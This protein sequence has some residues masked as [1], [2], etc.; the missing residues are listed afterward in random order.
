MNFIF[1][2][3]SV[4]IKQVCRKFDFQLK[5]EILMFVHGTVKMMGIYELDILLQSCCGFN[6]SYK[7]DHKKYIFHYI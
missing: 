5:T 6:A 7:A 2:I 1:H 3:T 4:F